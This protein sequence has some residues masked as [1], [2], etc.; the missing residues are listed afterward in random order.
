MTLWK[1]LKREGI[2]AEGHATMTEFMGGVNKR[3][4]ESA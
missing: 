4:K 3:E 1:V 2:S